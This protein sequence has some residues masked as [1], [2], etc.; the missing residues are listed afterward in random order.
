MNFIDSVF[1]RGKYIITNERSEHISRV[2]FIA[3]FAFVLQ[4][5]KIGLSPNPY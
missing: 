3:S 1:L 4:K 5:A 2:E